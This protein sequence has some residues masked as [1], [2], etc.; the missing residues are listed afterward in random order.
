MLV[1]PFC[2]DSTNSDKIRTLFGEAEFVWQ[3]IWPIISYLDF[4]CQ[5]FK[6]NPKAAS[7]NSTIPSLV[8]N[9]EISVKSSGSMPTR[10]AVSRPTPARFRSVLLSGA[11]NSISWLKLA[12]ALKSMSS[13]DFRSH[14]SSSTNLDSSLGFVRFLRV[15]L[16]GLRVICLFQNFGNHIYN[17]SHCFWFFNIK[18]QLLVPLLTRDLRAIRNRLAQ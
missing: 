10:S 17:R 2:I 8:G 12:N 4:F 16:V 5:R 1:S 6:G 18:D 3:T 13:K 11:T 14:D 15:V 7:A 9:S